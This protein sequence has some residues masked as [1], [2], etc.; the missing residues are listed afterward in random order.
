VVYEQE[1][2]K[3]A[4]AR[5]ERGWLKRVVRDDRNLV[6]VAHRC[7]GRHHS[8]AAV[9]PL[10]IVPD[11]VFEFAVEVMG[12]SRAFNYLERRYAGDD[13]RLDALLTVRGGEMLHPDDVVHEGR[14]W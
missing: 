10:A 2:R 7:H 5:G 11:S 3:L 12:A 6:P 14:A 9:Y 8:R 4:S 1:L 13:P